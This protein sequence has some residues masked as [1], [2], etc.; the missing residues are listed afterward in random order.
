MAT[1]VTRAGKGSALTHNEADANFVNLNNAKF[2]AGN[3]ASFTNLAYT[4]TLTG[5]T[6]VVNL[7]SGQVVKDASGNVAIGNATAFDKLDVF[8]GT[9]IRGQLQIV[10]A[11]GAGIACTSTAGGFQAIESNNGTATNMLAVNGASGEIRVSTNH[12]LNFLTSN[13]ERMRITSAG[14][15]GIGTSDPEYRLDIV[16][17][18]VGTTAGNQQYLYRGRTNTGNGDDYEVLYDRTSSGT[19]WTSADL[20]IR[21]NVDGSNG[22]SQIRFGGANFTSFWTNSAERMRIDSSGRVGI[23]TSAPTDSFQVGTSTSDTRATF[24]PNTPFAIGVANGAGFAGWIGGSGA[25]DT[26]VFSN[27]GGTERMRIDSSGNLLVGTTSVFNSGRLSVQG[28]TGLGA[29]IRGAGTVLRVGIS[30]VNSATLIAFRS[31]G[32][33]FDCGNITT[34]TANTVYSTSSDYRLKENVTP[35]VGALEKVA[36]LNPVSWTWKHMPNLTSQGFI[37]HELQ[38]VVPDAVTGEKDAVDKDGKPVYQGIDTSFLVATL[39]KAIQEQQALIENLTTR[40][41]ALEGN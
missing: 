7:G 1:I 3:N 8:G 18:S 37:A 15:V 6:G 19:N 36:S 20:V 28:N 10:N 35:L 29:T 9:T 39:T 30:D 16:T 41:T 11:S 17:P 22:Q 4:G 24:R 32:D 31:L 5:G 26:M 33:S 34:N 25:S 40:L 13:S 21:R 2:E 38:A 23:A 14:N 12:P 27:S